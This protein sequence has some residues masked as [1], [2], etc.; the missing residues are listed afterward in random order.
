MKSL[1]CHNGRLLSIT[2]IQIRPNDS[3]FR[4]SP[5]SNTVNWARSFVIVYKAQNGL[6]EL[7]QNWKYTD[8]SSAV[9]I[10]WEHCGSF[11]RW[12]N[13]NPTRNMGNNRADQERNWSECLHTVWIW[14]MP[15]L[16][17]GD[18]S[19]NAA[20]FAIFLPNRYFISQRN[21]TTV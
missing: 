20:R 5:K 12:T 9:Q 21:S 6:H 8:S 14:F 11:N 2:I 1:P 17:L 15:P 13:K 4:L 10:H 3:H 19:W 18:L 7:T 16:S